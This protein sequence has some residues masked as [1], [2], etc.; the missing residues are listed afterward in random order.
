[1]AHW[2]RGVSIITASTGYGFLGLTFTL[3]IFEFVFY[4]PA[5]HH[6][7]RISA[8][9]SELALSFSTIGG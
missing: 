4:T 1:M 7:V 9:V 6:F 5:V 3:G 8:G 2:F